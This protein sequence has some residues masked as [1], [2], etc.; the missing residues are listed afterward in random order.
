MLRQLCERD[1]C[2]P[3]PSVKLCLAAGHIA[4]KSDRKAL[5]KHFEQK[6]WRLFDE[7]WAFEQ[8][9]KAATSRYE[10]DVAHVVAKLLVRRKRRAAQQS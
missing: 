3:N 7:D 6:G 9:G 8:L 5:T 4:D 10:N 2:L 1:S